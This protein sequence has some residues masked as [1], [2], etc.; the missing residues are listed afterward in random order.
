MSDKPEWIENEEKL[1]IFCKWLID[2]SEKKVLKNLDEFLTELEKE[3]PK[4][5]NDN[6]RKQ[7]W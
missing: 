7:T 6:R 4:E 1:D 2:E 3:K 5:N